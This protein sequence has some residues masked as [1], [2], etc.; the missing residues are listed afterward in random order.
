MGVN[1]LRQKVAEF[2]GNKEK[3]EPFGSDLVVDDTRLELVTSRTS[4]GCATSC[5]NRPSAWIEYTRFAAL[6][7]PFPGNC[8]KIFFT[9]ASACPT[10]DGGRR[11]GCRGR[12]PLRRG[13][14]AAGGASPSPTHA[15]GRQEGQAPPLRRIRVA[16][17]NPFRHWRPHRPSVRTG[18][19]P[20]EG[21]ARYAADTA[22]GGGGKIR[23]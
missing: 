1:F 2:S 4:S 8:E 20:P 19:P 5:A 6:S 9:I 18:A 13:R 22:P 12:Q 23:R 11:T 16:A 15:A 17:A 14:G 3:S 21:E 7:S 10:G